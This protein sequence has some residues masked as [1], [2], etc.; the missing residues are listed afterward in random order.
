MNVLFLDYDG[1]VNTPMWQD[2]CSKPRLN[3]P[4]DG[5]VNNEQAVKWVSHFCKTFG[6]GIVVSSSWRTSRR[7]KEYLYNAGL[8]PDIQIVG[9]T[10]SLK[11]EVGF[12]EHTYETRYENRGDE[13]SAWLSLH[14]EVQAY[15][16]VDDE[17][18]DEIRDRDHFVKCEFG[19]G[20][21]YEEFFDAKVK[22][23]M[24]VMKYAGE[25]QDQVDGETDR[26]SENFG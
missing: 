13:I 17:D 25:V 11:E 10:P 7:Y 24:Q 23:E 4:A 8:D 12:G 22:H 18:R 1:V 19:H 14:P 16:I 26:E 3:F 9:K 15:L 20:F 2:G 21:G 6:Y 5:A